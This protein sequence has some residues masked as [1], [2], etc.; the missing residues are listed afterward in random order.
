[1]GVRS[2][3]SASDTTTR[4]KR[5]DFRRTKHDS[6]FSH[7]K[8]LIGAFD[9]EDHS[10]GKEG[11]ERYRTQN[12]PN[13]TSCPGVYELG[14]AQSGK[15]TRKLDSAS[16]IPVYLGQADNLRIRLQQYGR[17]GAH[18]ENGC[19]TSKTVDCQ[20]VFAHKGLGLF[21]DIFSR[22]LPIVYRCAP[23]K[24]KKEAEITEKQLLDRFD[25]AWNKGSNVSR[26]QDDIYKKLE[27]LESASK[28][29]LLAKKSLFSKQREVGIKIGNGSNTGNSSIFSRILGVRRLQARPV[30]SDC[31]EFGD[32]ICGV[33]TGHGSVCTS[34]PVA[35][36]KRCAVHKGPRISGYSLKLD[37]KVRVPPNAASLKSS[38]ET[39]Q[40]CND[41]QDQTRRYITENRHPCEK[42]TSKKVNLTCGF[43]LE[44]GSPCKRC[45]VQGNKRCLEHKGRRI[46]RSKLSS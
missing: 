37:T 22:G 4:L 39:D 3:S 10:M 33:A 24:S 31:G 7:W 14:V 16:V 40:E 6:A 28:F 1:M 17:N 36:R 44:D 34:S 15:E 41:F 45:P 35:G 46:R 11:V 8:I 2:R 43:I 9:W 18:L 20:S 26:R 13:W 19:S 38:V 29:S 23:M 5:E 21:T 32:N 25:Y 42:A 27:L 30:Q 12:L